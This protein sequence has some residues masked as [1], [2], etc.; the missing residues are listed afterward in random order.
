MQAS[1]LDPKVPEFVP[2]PPTTSFDPLCQKYFDVEKAYAEISALDDPMD[3]M[4]Y[5]D[6]L[7]KYDRK[8]LG[9]REQQELV[10]LPLPKEKG[11]FSPRT[12]TDSPPKHYSIHSKP[13]TKYKT[14]DSRWHTAAE[15]EK[16]KKRVAPKKKTVRQIQKEREEQEE[17]LQKIKL[18]NFP[19]KTIIRASNKFHALLNVGFDTKQSSLENGL[20]GTF[21]ELKKST[22][23]PEL[24]PI[25]I[26]EYEQCTPDVCRLWDDNQYLDILSSEGKKEVKF[27]D[28]SILITLNHKGSQKTLKISKYIEL[29]SYLKN[30]RKELNREF[31]ENPDSTK[32]INLDK[33]LEHIYNALHKIL[34]HNTNVLNRADNIHQILT[35]LYMQ[36]KSSYFKENKDEWHRISSL[37]S[38]TQ[39]ELTGNEID[40]KPVISNPV[41]LLNNKLYLILHNPQIV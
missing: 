41:A 1:Q 35:T 16:I 30:L 17:Y 20:L 32:S 19:E 22:F 26:Q 27:I 9:N 21:D 25:H 4:E 40:N 3:K 23:S 15:A 12:P 29:N 18:K 7:C 6:R 37:Y 14:I 13:F 10:V 31:L 33:K 5:R 8:L 36:R 34:S 24:E 39:K 2:K 38:Q 11:E 28:G